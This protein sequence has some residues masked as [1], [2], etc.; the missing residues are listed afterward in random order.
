MFKIGKTGMQQLSM[1]VFNYFLLKNTTRFDTLI[2]MCVT[3][4]KGFI[5]LYAD[6]TEG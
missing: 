4:K 6:E 2:F 3:T 1:P 5:L